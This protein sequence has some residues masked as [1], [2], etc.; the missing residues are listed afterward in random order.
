MDLY[1]KILIGFAVVLSLLGLYLA[2]EWLSA[3]DAQV[4][5]EAKVEAQ[6]ILYDK[7]VQQQKDL[8]TELQQAKADQARQLADVSRNFSQ[9]QSPS[10]LAALLSQITKQPVTVVT[11]AATAQN[12]NPTPVIQLP[13]TPQAKVYFQDCESCK[14]NYATA[15]K[16]LTIANT[17][18][19]LDKQK[20]EYVTNE[21][22]TWKKAAT[23]GSWVK[24]AGVRA[25]D[26][27]IDAAIT[28][29]ITCGSGHCK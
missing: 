25:R 4:K 18:A 5:A 19:Q 24:R 6:Q 3:H 13:D 26:F 8:A 7:V 15:Q 2:Y 22:D 29:A 27:L 1:H 14:V 28:T 9:A 12:P 21:R 10:Q 20:I 16:E 17:N 11:P 23:G